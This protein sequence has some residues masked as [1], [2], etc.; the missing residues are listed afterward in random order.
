MTENGV[1]REP[2]YD[3][4]DAARLLRQAMTLGE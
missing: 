1:L 3:A 2:R 4:M